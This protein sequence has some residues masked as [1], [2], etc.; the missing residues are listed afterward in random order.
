MA[1]ISLLT[2]FLFLLLC[3]LLSLVMPSALF[4]S[5]GSFWVIVMGLITGRCRG[6]EGGREGGRD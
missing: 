1:A 6:R 4:Y 5:A 3:L 2:N